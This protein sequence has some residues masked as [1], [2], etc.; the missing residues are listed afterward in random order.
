MTSAVGGT[1]DPLMWIFI[2]TVAIAIATLIIA[3]AARNR[4]G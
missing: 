1:E 2:A 3:R 4:R